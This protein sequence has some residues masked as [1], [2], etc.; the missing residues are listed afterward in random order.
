M[1]YNIF[2][3][4]ILSDKINLSND[5][6][7]MALLQS[8]YTPDIDAH[9]VFSDVTGEVSGSGYTAGGQV[10][11]GLNFTQDNTNDVGK[12][13]A[14]NVA[15]DNSVI[16]SARFGLVYRSGAS[17]GDSYLVAYQSFGSDKS[18][19]NAKFEVEIDSSGLFVTS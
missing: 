15:W 10:I 12:L 16:T 17:S 8:N 18:T 2:K 4:N 9:T 1:F 19:N 7:K 6:F 5:T 11:T 14:S 3:K 13:D